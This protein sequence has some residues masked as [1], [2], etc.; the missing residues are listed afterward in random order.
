MSLARDYAKL[1]AGLKQAY[2]KFTQTSDLRD[3]GKVG[4]KVVTVSEQLTENRLRELW[5]QHLDGKTSIGIVPID[6]DNCCQWGAIDVDDFTLDLKGLAKKLHKLKLPLVLCRSKSG[7]AHI[8]LFVFDPVPAIIMQRKLKDIAACL[9]FGQAEIF[10]KQTKLLIERGDKGSALNM[11]YF[12]GEDSTRYGYGNSGVALTPEEFIELANERTITAKELEEYVIE[13]SQDEE[14]LDQA[15]PCLQHLI[16]QGFPKGT[17][18]SGL[19]NVGVFLRKKYEDDWEQRLEQVN[20][21]YMSPPLVAQEVLT[22]IK[23]VQKKDYF[24]RCNDQPIAG[25]CNSTVCRTRKFGIGSSGGTPQFSNLTKQNSDPPIWFLDVEGGRLELETDDLLNQNRFQ[26]KCMDALNIIPP[27]VKDNVW[28][29]LIQQLLD[30]LTVIEMPDD[31]S[32]EGH[33]KELLETFCTERPAR[34]RD[35]ILLHK[36]WTDAYKTYFRVSDLVDYL[37]RNGFKEY[38][39]N[40]ITSKLRQ[41]GGGAHFFNI[42][43]KGTNVWYVPEFETQNEVFSIPKDITDIDEEI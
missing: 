5:Q 6:E 41:M 13:A 22:I 26:R 37:N 2:G 36:P 30:N 20:M 32:N 35:E 27:R 31:A 25:H 17:R 43:G 33:F 19:F 38:A 23:Q 34:E 24:Y 4:G 18:N 8:F 9:G 10:P 7:G 29:Q 14:W 15:P 11:P 1:F 42:K 16:T 39:R 21:N 28:R 3:D 40:K 12:G